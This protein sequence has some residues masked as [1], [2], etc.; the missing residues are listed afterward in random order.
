M[1]GV[2][3]YMSLEDS[4]NCCSLKVIFNHDLGSLSAHNF[5]NSLYKVI[6]CAKFL[7]G[8]SKTFFDDTG[9]HK[10]MILG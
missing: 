8:N 9:E 1:D 2:D 5:S 10:D 3:E 7:L 4:L 6:K